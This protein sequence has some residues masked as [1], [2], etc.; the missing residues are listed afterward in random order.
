V[1]HFSQNNFCGKWEGEEGREERGKMKDERGE[2][3]EMREEREE[4]W[5]MLRFLA[6]RCKIATSL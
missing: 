1:V 3:K 2:G 5:S 6:F 4:R